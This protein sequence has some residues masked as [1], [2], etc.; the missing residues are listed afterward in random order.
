MPVPD[1][2]VSSSLVS[3][4]SPEK[5]VSLSVAIANPKQSNNTIHKRKRPEALIQRPTPEECKFAVSELGKLH[6]D[7]IDKCREIRDRTTVTTNVASDCKIDKDIGSA[8]TTATPK[9][10]AALQT[11][12]CGHQ[13]SIL[14]GVVST[15]LSQ[16]TTASNST[17]AFGNLKKAVPDWNL[18]AGDYSGYQDTIEKAIHCGGLAQKKAANIVDLCRILEKEQGTISLEYLRERSNEQI[19][20]DL[21][22]FKGLG[23]KTVSCVLLFTLGRA[24]FPVDTH[25]YRITNQHGWLGAE[26]GRNRETAYG[27]LNA[28][29]PDRLKLELHCL[30]VQHGRECHR[31]AAR[32]KPQFPPKDGTKLVCPLVH[33]PKIAAMSSDSSSSRNIKSCAEPKARTFAK[34]KS[35]N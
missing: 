12:A 30:L 33:L 32:G 6:P 18:V 2:S 8:A 7:V 20:K 15:L 26:A 9:S 31:C 14:D 24:D 22:R 1:N 5:V 11:S 4:I 25:V 27:H 28:I 35:E 17:R 29:V 13:P 19:Q 21:L 16:N 23:P 10:T 34:V 3:S